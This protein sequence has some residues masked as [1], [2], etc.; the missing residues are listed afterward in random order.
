MCTCITFENGRRYFGRT[1]D[2]VSSYGEEIVVIP[3]KFNM[4]FAGVNSSHHAMIGVAHIANGCPLMYDGSNEKGLA[5]AALNFP[6]CAIYRRPAEGMLNVPS[7]ALMPKLLGECSCIE[8]AKKMLAKVNITDESFDKEH[9]TTTL[10]WMLADK[11][12]VIVVEQTEDGLHIHQNHLG[13][14]TNSPVFDEQVRLLSE[15]NSDELPGGFSSVSRFARAAYAVRNAASEDSAEGDINRFFHMTETVA[16]VK[17]L[18]KTR[19]GNMFTAYTSCYDTLG[20]ICY[21]TTYSDRTIRA[22]DMH[23]TDIDSETAARYSMHDGEGIRRLGTAS[24]FI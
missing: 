19:Y 11:S 8:E 21:F 2:V 18:N 1:L 22:V 5:A 14:M 10:H 15:R 17:G 20:G 3:R 9:P 16:Q 13:I 24:D 4:A 6:G 7:F 12:D 23:V